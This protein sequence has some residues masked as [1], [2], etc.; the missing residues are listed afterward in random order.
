MKLNIQKIYLLKSLSLATFF[1]LALCPV[2]I[3]ALEDTS[4]ID[5]K[6]E[7]TSLEKAWLK[8]HKIINIAGPKSFPPF[9]YYDE[10]EELKGISAD[11][12]FNI[13]AALG[14][15][16]NID[17]NLPWP[18]VLSK[19]KDKKIDLIP[20][21]AI[22]KDREAYLNFSTPYLSFPLVI[23]TRD[24]SP[25]IGG[26]EDL[27][28]KTLATVKRNSTPTW[29]K[30]DGIQF[31]PLY[32]ESPLKG[33]E[34]VSY[35]KADARIENL[36]AAS[37]LI[38][39]N[40]LTNL[41]I[42][43]PTSYDKYN[44][45]MAVREDW[46]EL[47]SI[48]NKALDQINPQQ[49]SI[50]RNNWLSVRYEHGISKTDIIK[51]VFISALFSSIILIT[52]LRWNR[53][54]RAEV[55][56]RNMTEEKLVHS[57]KRFRAII[58]GASN[59]A[60]KGYNEE[61]EITFWNQ[62]STDLYGYT[63]TE[64]LGEKLEKLII[65]DEMREEVINLHHKWVNNGQE[66]P[67]EELDLIDKHGNIIP[68]Y[69]SH[70]ML[71]TQN[72]K[73]MFCLDVDLKPIRQ[74]QNALNEV[75]EINEIMI[76]ES[77][78]GISIYDESGQC[79]YANTSIGKIIGATKDQVLSQ[80]FNHIESWKNSG[81][82]E[83]AKIAIANGTTERQNLKLTSSFG[84][85]IAV[86]CFFVPFKKD[87]KL[88]LMFMLT[89][90]SDTQK[91]KDALLESERKYRHLFKNAPSGYYEIDFLKS[92]FV[93]VNEIMCEYTGYSEKEF[94]SMNPIDLLAEESKTPFIQRLKEESFKKV[95][96]DN[97]E[98]TIQKKNGK[99]LDV[100]LS[101]DFIYSDGR[102]TGAR[103]V[104]HD[105][106]ELKKAE[107][108]KIK[109]QKLV[110]EQKKLALV[111][112]IAGKMAHDFN[113]ILG[114][115][116]GN[117]EL[118]LIDCND[119]ELKQSLELIFEQTLRGKNLTKN[120]VA[121]A[122]DQEPKHEYFRIN[123]KIDLVLNLLKKDLKGI[124]LIREEK[125][126]VPE[127]L[128]D[129]GMIE[130]ALVNLVQNSI[131]ALSLVDQAQITLRTYGTQN[132]VCFDIEDNGCGIPENQIDNIY[133]PAF[134]LK[135]NRD[136]TGSYKPGIKGTGYG[137]SNIKKYIE[138]HKGSIAVES[139]L[140][141]GTKFK[142]CLPVTQ[143]E[144]TKVEI[145]TLEQECTY[146]EK[147]ILLVE[148]E[149]AIS[150]IQYRILTSKPC[151]HKVDIAQNGQMAI[152]LFERNQYEL[153]SLDYM[154]LGEI[155]GMDVYRHIRKK[156][157]EIPILFISGNINFLESIQDLKKEDKH[158]DHLSKPCQNKEYI[159]SINKLMASIQ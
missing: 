75:S 149:P 140:G 108:D 68:V 115:I 60:I 107:N 66:I 150:E 135:G 65:P 55:S 97:I 83:K 2:N 24:D 86:D 129:P 88:Q 137:M 8:S 143:K 62:A 133:E 35:G 117:T 31:N 1:I 71:E 44:L 157:R 58:E 59:I 50:I 152:D 61:R 119:P 41:K 81:L 113:N 72:G 114:I 30:R 36:A 47:L 144:L 70:I 9:H 27:H 103:V 49:H 84:K 69:C 4:K 141:A 3:S 102:L 80:N 131:H 73:E 112:Q 53:R 16:V 120:L 90:I 14:L 5:I 101:S 29:L 151:H 106:S 28:D 85:K 110:G 95:L 51:W 63:E 142:I 77:P 67:E 121:F 45:H 136:V 20:C 21:A 148:D 74:A 12:I 134:T 154:L 124:E 118:S 46:P 147:N 82:L 146:F 100:F 43:A 37:Y 116:M 10:N 52:I 92:K 7:L 18:D 105:I 158:I 34:A 57:E 96:S 38:N 40:G 78:I 128:A 25:F 123:E 64:A 19:A 54:L 99:V 132:S 94:L 156:N 6:L 91:I 87:G 122:K 98:Y 33:L 42:A 23:I 126:G 104:V 127:L 26:I 130:H 159:V 139:T 13:I 76:S 89:D 109:A 48:I 56:A 11:Y 155:N 32:V 15:K 145:N 138:Q 93:L 125:P 153:V 17:K 39:Q 79:I 22:T 111:G